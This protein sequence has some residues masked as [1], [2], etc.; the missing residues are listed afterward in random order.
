MDNHDKAHYG[1]AALL[2]CGLGYGGA[3]LHKTASLS[4]V[5]PEYHF[6]ASDID[7]SPFK[8]QDVL[9]F[10]APAA[11]EAPYMMAD[12]ITKAG[13]HAKVEMD[14]L[15]HEGIWV[16]PDNAD[17]HAMG[18]RLS[19]AIGEPVSVG[20]FAAGEQAYHTAYFIGVGVP[21]RK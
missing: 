14:S 7:A 8:G 17:G 11:G 19:K 20:N 2:L 4:D 15:S 3:Q 21:R 9:V 12:A 1:I 6:T 18:D 10:A 16:A 13:G 5:P